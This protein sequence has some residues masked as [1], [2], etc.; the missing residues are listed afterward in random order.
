MHAS[1]LHEHGQ[2]LRHNTLAKA[3]GKTM[4]SAGL[5]QAI[6]LAEALQHNIHGMESTILD[7]LNALEAPV[8]EN[9]HGENIPPQQVVLLPT[10]Q[11]TFNKR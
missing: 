7:Q 8:P 3:R 5:Q 10:L 4:Q 6:I 9:L 2:R 11:L 1:F